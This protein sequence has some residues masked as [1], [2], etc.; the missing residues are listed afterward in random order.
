MLH[1]SSVQWLARVDNFNVARRFMMEAQSHLSTPLNG[2]FFLNIV[3]DPKSDRV[4]LAENPQIEQRIHESRA[5]ISSS[6]ELATI[7]D[8]IRKLQEKDNEVK[9]A[10]K[11][12]K[13][14]D[15][16]MW[17]RGMSWFLYH[18]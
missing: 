9:E 12:K 4:D 11:R 5:H 6:N 18:P 3:Q 1:P 10:L 14:L 8:E 13:E 7:E 2:E 16:L 17:P 15:I